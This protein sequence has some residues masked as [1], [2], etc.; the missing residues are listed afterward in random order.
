VR[1]HGHTAAGHD[2]RLARRRVQ[3]PPIPFAGSLVRVI[4]KNMLWISVSP[5]YASLIA[6]RR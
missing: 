5:A 4:F 2:W 3:P 1:V 6:T